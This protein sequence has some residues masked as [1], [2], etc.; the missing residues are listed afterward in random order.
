MLNIRINFILHTRVS[1]ISKAFA[2]TLCTP[3]QRIK[4]A[5]NTIDVFLFCFV[6]LIVCL[7]VFVFVFVC[8]FVCFF[9]WPQIKPVLQVIILATAMLVSFC[10]AGVSH[11]L[12]H[13][14]I[15]NHNCVI[16]ILVL[17]ICW[18]LKFCYEVNQKYSRVLL[19]SL[20]RAVQ[21]GNQGLG[22]NGCV[23]VCTKPP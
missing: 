8:L 6:C 2:I 12:D 22:Q 10:T 18:N 23:C 20:Y 7:F 19:F 4:V 21:K 1:S 9:K 14:T 11:Y 16:R 15:H 3:W 17:T 5:K 13:T